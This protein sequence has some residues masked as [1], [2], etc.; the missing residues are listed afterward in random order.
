MTYQRTDYPAFPSGYTRS[1][2]AAP[3]MLDGMEVLFDRTIGLAP[4]T[5]VP[6]KDTLA[7]KE[8]ARD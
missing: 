4:V 3:I 6:K 8:A 7:T 2:G 5:L 1:L